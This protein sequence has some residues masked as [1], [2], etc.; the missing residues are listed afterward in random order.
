MPV[1]PA[2]SEDH[3]MATVLQQVPGFQAQW[4]EHL[5]AHLGE[6]TDLVDDLA[7]LAAYAHAL[8]A[9]GQDADLRSVLVVAEQLLHDGSAAVQDAVCSGFLES[10]ADPLLPGE[11][12]LARLLAGLG[13]ASR[14]YLR[15]WQGFGGRRLPGL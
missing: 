5:A 6:P 1:M 10:L 3:C 4:D 13:P 2:L 14:A 9:G 12:G 8:M 15:H 11:P 7:E